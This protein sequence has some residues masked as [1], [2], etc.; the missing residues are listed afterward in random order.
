VATITVSEFCIVGTNNPDKRLLER[1]ASLLVGATDAFARDLQ[2]HN[3]LKLKLP[4]L[5]LPVIVT[6]AKLYMARYDPVE[7]D[8]QTG[9]FFPDK[10]SEIEGEVPW[11]RFT[12]TLI[13]GRG[14]DIG[15]RSVFVVSAT[16]FKQFLELL[17]FPPQQMSNKVSVSI[18]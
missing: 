13:A 2:E 16:S 17:E 9:E 1:D 8:L 6:T 12:K 14:F 4:Y 11:I 3:R 7:I 10:P 5:V 15:F 18:L